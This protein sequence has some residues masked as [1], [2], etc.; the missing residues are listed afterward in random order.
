[1]RK[2]TKTELSIS[3]NEDIIKILNDEFENRS[4]FIEYCIIK[5]LENNPEFKKRIEKLIIF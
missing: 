5:E 2:K 1:M 3:L 4:K